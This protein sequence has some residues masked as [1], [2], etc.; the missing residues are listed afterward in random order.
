LKGREKRCD[1]TIWKASPARMYSLQVSTI[2]LKS[3]F[4]MLA[5]GSGRASRSSALSV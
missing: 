4:D 5:C 1:G 2:A 3:S